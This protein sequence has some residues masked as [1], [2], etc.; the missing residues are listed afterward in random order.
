[1]S[2]LLLSISVAVFAIEPINT[3]KESN[4]SGKITDL[5]T[6]ETLPG[7]SVYFPDLKTG[8]VSKSD[9]AYSISRLPS[10]KV[11]VQVSSTGYL[12]HSTGLQA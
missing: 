7:V 2:W 3:I 1:M 5:N 6:G 8:T 12:L 10:A 4:L 11:L 9:G